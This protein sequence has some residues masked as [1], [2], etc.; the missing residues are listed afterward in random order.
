MIDATPL[1]RLYARRRARRLARQHA[2]REQERQ[3]LRL[4]RRARATCFGRDHDFAAIADVPSFQRRVPLRRFEETWEAYWRRDFPVL[5]DVTWPGTI[6]YFAVTSGTTSGRTKHIPLSRAMLAANRRA[7]LDL[8]THHLANRPRSRI[9]AGKSFLLGGSTA[10]VA[11]APGIHSG[12]LSG[13]G[14]R[15]MSR[16]VRL[17]Y[18]PPDHVGRIEDWE[19]KVEAIARAVAHEDIRAVSGTPSWLLILF[20]RLA[21]LRP[22]RGRGL[23][24]HFPDL[25]MLAHGGVNFAP[26]RHR[27]AE[28]LEGSGAETREVYAASE[29]YFANADRGDGQG[30]RLIV[31]N[32]L[33]YEFVE[34]G[35]LDGPDPARHWLGDVETGVDYAIVVTSCAGLWAHVVGD[36][37]AF[38]DLDPPRLLVTGRTAYTLSAFGE[39]LIEE[40]IAQAVAVAAGAIGADVSDYSVAPAFPAAP[41]ELGGHVYVVEFAGGAPTSEALARFARRLDRSLEQ[42]NDDYAAHRAGGYGL[43]APR[44]HAVAAGTF[45]AWMKKRGRLGG[46]HKV[47]RIVNDAPLFDD[48]MAFAGAGS[49]SAPGAVPHR[50]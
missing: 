40:E 4:V 50:R 12:D 31:D 45:A 26:Y 47:P 19:R 29:G 13:I 16:W 23:A 30:M 48:L 37:V 1:L 18:F 36:T 28:L 2:A 41:G 33:F 22:E 38:T 3:L 43:R 6:P 39:H 17:R 25:E 24:G 7:A 10:A 5:T 14:P 46:Q 11:L 15:E 27:F 44:V 9:L 8:Y 35:A 49:A 42:A 21:E 32:G 34:T 20:D